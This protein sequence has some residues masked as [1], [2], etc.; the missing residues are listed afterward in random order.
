MQVKKWQKATIE[1][2]KIPDT[3]PEYTKRWYDVAS[4]EHAIDNRIGMDSEGET[5]LLHFDNLCDFVW[6]L[7]KRNNVGYL[8]ALVVYK[9]AYSPTFTRCLYVRQMIHHDL[10]YFVSRVWLTRVATGALLFCYNSSNIECMPNFQ[11]DLTLSA[12]PDPPLPS[13]QLLFSFHAEFQKRLELS[14]SEEGIPSNFRLFQCDSCF[15]RVGGGQLD[16]S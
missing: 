2:G 5:I 14:L 11:A 9:V 10:Y 15:S 1:C 6:I 8:R 7:R 4:T 12:I 3:I 13:K 16:T